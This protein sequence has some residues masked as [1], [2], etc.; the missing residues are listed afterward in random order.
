MTTDPYLMNTRKSKMHSME[1]DMCKE[2][3]REGYIPDSLHHIEEG[4]YVNESRET[5]RGIEIFNVPVGDNM[6]VED[7]LRQKA[8]EVG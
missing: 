3:R 8:R 7:V 4:I 1:E 6:Y 5:L 2:A